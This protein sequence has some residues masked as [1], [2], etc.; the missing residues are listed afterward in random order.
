MRLGLI[1][2]IHSNL[3]ALEG[4]V[5]DIRGAGIDDLVCLGDVVSLG[6]HPRAALRRVG[7]LGCPVVMGNCDAFMLE[8]KI[9]PGDDDGAWISASDAWS[10]GQLDDS[11]L[12]FI[13][14]F[15]PTIEVVVGDRSVLC[16]HGSPRS[17]DDVI[18]AGTRED[19]IEEL[20]AGYRSDIYA[21]GHTHFQ[22]LR[23]IGS[24]ELINPG[25]VG[26]AYDR[27]HPAEEVRCAPWAEYAIVEATG[28]G[29]EI[30][31]RR[32]PYD[33]TEIAHDLELS[34]MPHARWLAD[35]WR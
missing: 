22:L 5:E 24:A 18:D 11:D 32:V 35:N 34:D 19:R 16:F 21:G 9:E 8:P 25:S 31:F 33:R 23:R 28:N 6:P 10:A 12:D 3:P 26:M 17:F 4:V 14:S 27:T 30:D 13:R 1:A 20:V 2:D 15:R 29:L 7:E